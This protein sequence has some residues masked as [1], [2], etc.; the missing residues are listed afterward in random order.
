L[1]IAPYAVFVVPP[2]H[3]LTQTHTKQTPATPKRYIP[4]EGDFVV[5]VVVDRMSEV[6]VVGGGVLM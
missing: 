4:A 2:C 5:G 6:L 1:V 3:S